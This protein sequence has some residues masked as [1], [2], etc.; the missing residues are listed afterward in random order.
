VPSVFTFFFLDWVDSFGSCSTFSYTVKKSDG[1]NIPTILLFDEATR[2]FTIDT[3]QIAET[4][5]YTLKVKGQLSVG[6]ASSVDTFFLRLYWC[7][8]T[9]ITKD[10]IPDS[11]IT[12]S[13]VSST[14][15][16]SFN[17]FTE[18]YGTC[19]DFTYSALLSDGSLLPNIIFFD[20][21]T[22]TFSVDRTQILASA[23]YDIV[24][25]GSLNSP[26]P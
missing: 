21:I 19:G 8:S 24:V 16:L 14:G 15:T 18:S 10:I 1:S 26:W 7:D 2:T 13:D 9:S 3:N 12:F 5:T 20:P 17:A 22:R 11:E 23:S 25:K 6:G 4:A